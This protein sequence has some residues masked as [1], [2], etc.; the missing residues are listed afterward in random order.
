MLPVSLTWLSSPSFILIIHRLGL[1]IVSPISWMLCAWVVFALTFSLAEVPTSYTWSLRSEIS[2]NLLASL[3]YELFVWLLGFFILNFISVWFYFSDSIL[4]LN[5]IFISWIVFII[6]FNC[7]LCISWSSKR[8]WFM[9]PLRSLNIFITTILISLSCV[10]VTLLFSV[11]IIIGFL[12]SR[13]VILSRPFMFVFCT[14]IRHFGVK[15]LEVMSYGLKFALWC[16]WE[17]PDLVFMVQ[18]FCFVAA[19][20]RCGS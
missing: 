10:S 18:A 2:F 16:S 7:F 1:F 9:S 14:G 15:M 17:T 13:G 5:S 3:F 19:V 4:L 6:L 12:G 11:P 8:P 20:T